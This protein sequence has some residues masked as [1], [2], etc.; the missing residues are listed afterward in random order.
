MKKFFLL[1]I[2]L[3]LA[4]N[5]LTLN[6]AFCETVIPKGTIV[7][8]YAKKP[9]STM[10]YQEG[11]IIYFVNPSDVWSGEE[12]IFPKNTIFTG[13]INFLKMPVQGVNGAFKGKITKVIL[14]TGEQF[15]IN[16]VIHY[17]G[18]TT[19]GGELTS[20]ASYNRAVHV[21]QGWTFMSGTL[22][23]VPSGEYEFGQ[24]AT[25]TT[26]DPVFILLEDDYIMR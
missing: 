15:N 10:N 20:P 21:T 2:P 13:H 16:A 24:H 6:V 26:K 9:I 1:L 7:Q 5:A 14:P 19:V 23:W 11:D 17:K 8:V 25:L 12:N 22:Q 3:L 4:L 18:G